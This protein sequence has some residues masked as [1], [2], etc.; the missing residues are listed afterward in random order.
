MLRAF[1][2]GLFPGTALVSVVAGPWDTLVVPA[3]GA[4]AAEPVGAACGTGVTVAG[5]LVIGIVGGTTWVGLAESEMLAFHGSGVGSIDRLAQSKGRPP[6]TIAIMTRGQ[7]AV[8]VFSLTGA[9][10]SAPGFPSAPDPSGASTVPGSGCPQCAHFAAPT[11]LILPHSGLGQIVR[12]IEHP[13]FEQKRVPDLF[14]CWQ[15]GQRMLG[16]GCAVGFDGALAGYKEYQI[17]VSWAGPSNSP[18][19]F[20]NTDVEFPRMAYFEGSSVSSEKTPKVS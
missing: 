13:Q 17:G 12:C 1:A 11:S 20:G 4:G 14:W 9:A 3:G 5:A 6:A 7:A 15:N 19:F 10:E 2:G 18:A 16:I 8:R